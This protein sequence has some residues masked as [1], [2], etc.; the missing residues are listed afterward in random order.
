MASDPPPQGK[1]A[2][3]S[4]EPRDMLESLLASV[5]AFVGEITSL[6]VEAAPDNENRVLMRSTGES[7]TGQTTRLTGFIRESAA[8]LSPAQ[9]VELDRFLR[10]QDG[11]AIA[12]RAVEG[13]RQVL[14]GGVLGKLIHW[15]SQHLK[16]LKK[17]LLAI[18]HLIFDLLHIPWP[19][20]LDRII[21]IVDELLDLLLSLLSEVFGMDFG[22]AA[23]A[24]SEQEVNFLRE[25]AALESV[26]VA[27]TGRRTSPQDEP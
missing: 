27:Q 14:K 25:M 6:A 16:E 21:Q 12:T 23:R 4:S 2:Q 26:R 24:L 17:I 7:L 8:R 5:E 13:T 1:R 22:V 18:L 15:I 11:D 9:R 3:P 19:D 20:W 10:V